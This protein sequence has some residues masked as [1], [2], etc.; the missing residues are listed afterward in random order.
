MGRAGR[1]ALW[2]WVCGVIIGCGGVEPPTVQEAPPGGELV[3]VEPP[4]VVEEHPA[5]EPPPE[6]GPPPREEPPP[7]ACD[8]GRRPFLPVATGCE[9][10]VCDTTTGQWA[11]R[12]RADGTACQVRDC[13]TGTCQAGVCQ[14]APLADGTVCGPAANCQGPRACQQGRCTEPASRPLTRGAQTWAYTLTLAGARPDASSFFVAGQGYFHQGVDRLAADARDPGVQRGKDRTEV[15]FYIHAG[16]PLGGTMLFQSAVGVEAVSPVDLLPLWNLPLIEALRPERP[17]PVGPAQR[18]VPLR[19]VALG[20]PRFLVPV[21]DVALQRSWMLALEGPEG[22][23]ERVWVRDLPGSLGEAVADAVGTS[24]VLLRP[25]QAPPSA[26]GTLIAF[27]RDGEELWRRPAQSAP[28]AVAGR[29]LVLGDGEGVDTGTGRT[30]F[31]LHLSASER[32][33][34]EGVIATLLDGSH[35]VRVLIDAVERFDARTGLRVSRVAIPAWSPDTWLPW[36]LPATPV[37]LTEDGGVLRV[38]SVGASWCD[39][40]YPMS[41]EGRTAVCVDRLSR[42]GELTSFDTPLSAFEAGSDLALTGAVFHDDSLLVS[43]FCGDDCTAAT[44][45]SLPGLKPARWGWVTPWG[46]TAWQSRPED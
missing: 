29:L 40:E 20:G 33:S 44:V 13:H 27:S 38:R 19:A 35:L 28:V 32:A 3:E 9:E 5:F 43:Y 45:L 37:L 22:R 31:H 6:K 16:Q 39:G 25:F 36:Q 34:S 4:V 24:Y 14:D 21:R 26:D 7:M 1:G 23:A 11:L 2:L 46:N 18:P 17:E 15:P 30:R 10:P 42:S 12:P 8:P 41:C